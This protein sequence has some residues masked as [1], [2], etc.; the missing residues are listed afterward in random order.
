MYHSLIWFSSKLRCWYKRLKT[1]WW[2]TRSLRL[3]CSFIVLGAATTHSSVCSGLTDVCSNP[4]TSCFNEPLRLHK[5]NKALYLWCV[6][7]D[8]RPHL[9]ANDTE[10][11]HEMLLFC[12]K[13][14][15]LLHQLP[16]GFSPFSKWP[17]MSSESLIRCCDQEEALLFLQETHCLRWDV[18]AHVEVSDEGRLR[19]PGC[20]CGP[21]RL[22]RRTL[23]AD[24]G[25]NPSIRPGAGLWCTRDIVLCSRGR[26]SL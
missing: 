9:W 6:F 11:S 26:L 4:V 21:L 23:G 15:N 16:S 24:P 12:D 10:G 18:L 20:L 1:H 5:R 25:F 14:T 19:R 17:I 2:V 13:A 3:T 8:L 22:R 7:R